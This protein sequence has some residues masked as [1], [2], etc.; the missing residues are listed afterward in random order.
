[1]D[2]WVIYDHPIDHPGTFVARRW[3]AGSGGEDDV[4]PTAELMFADTI[5][6][7]REEMTKRGLVC[8][9][10]SQRDDEKIVEA[11]L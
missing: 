1:M 10:R 11:W 5:E 2:V 9:P 4:R 6:E 8:I 3:V 7:L